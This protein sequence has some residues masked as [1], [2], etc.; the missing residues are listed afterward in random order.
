MTA[1]PAPGFIVIAAHNEETVIE[2]CLDSLRAA[3]AAGVRVA[4][5]CNGCTDRTA[6]LARGRSGVVVVELD[7]ASKPAA[8]RA[9]DSLVSGGPRI[10]LDADVVMTSR[11]VLDVFSALES[12]PALVGRPPVRFDY[13]HA[14]LLVRRWYAVRERLPSIQGVLWGAGCYALSAAG[15]ERFGQFPDLVSDDLFIDSLFLAGERVIV[16]T[17][18]VVVR[19]P[20]RAADLVR[21]LQRSYRTQ[22]EVHRPGGVV[23]A[24]QRGQL[25]DLAGLLRRN[26]GRVGDVA[27]YVAIV[28][29]SHVRARRARPSGWER[30]NSSREVPRTD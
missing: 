14:G 20:R 25:R 28:L 7:V 10:Y 1:A 11:A 19:T 24:G 16:A 13:A 18:P 4:V 3:I 21:I 8:L 27:V 2:R 12:G 5:V 23:S 29:Y 15:R 22:R 17:D 9:G 26:P 6:E 30:D